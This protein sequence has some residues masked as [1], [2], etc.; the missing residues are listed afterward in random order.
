MVV[1]SD[2]RN[3]SPPRPRLGNPRRGGES[4][5]PGLRLHK[6]QL[7]CRAAVRLPLTAPFLDSS[8][9]LQVPQPPFPQPQQRSWVM[10]RGGRQ[11][12]IETPAAG[13]PIQ[14]TWD[15]GAEQEGRQ[16]ARRREKR[17]AELSCCAERG[18]GEGR[19]LPSS[20]QGLGTRGCKGEQGGVTI[21]QR[22]GRTTEPSGGGC[23]GRGHRGEPPPRFAEAYG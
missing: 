15:L 12:S 18:R 19:G 4:Q 1:S 8:V 16:G 17:T 10:E 7:S 14:A 13:T 11:W 3:Y 2:P 20:L 9:E 6:S 21:Q 23:R 22:S 5:D